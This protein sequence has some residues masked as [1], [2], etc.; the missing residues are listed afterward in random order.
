VDIENYYKAVLVKLKEKRKE[1][2]MS[3]TYVSKHSSVRNDTLS[4][5]ESGKRKIPLLKMI[6]L[7]ELYG[8][9]IDIFFKEVLDYCRKNQ[10]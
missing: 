9:R 1:Q 10:K 8:V 4:L 7:L 6:E 2:R 5:Y 3:M